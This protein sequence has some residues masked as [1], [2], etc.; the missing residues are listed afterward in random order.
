MLS[1]IKEDTSMSDIVSIDWHDE[2]KQILLVTYHRDGWQ[3]NDFFI[4]LKQ[5]YAFIDSVNHTVDVLVDVQNSSWIPKGGSLLSGLR[6]I[7]EQHPRQGLTIIVGAKGLVASIARSM[8]KMLGENRRFHF[9]ATMEEAHQLIAKAQ[10][11]RLV[12]A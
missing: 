3:W 12:Q 10:A 7:E 1:K 2:D 6:K 9:V 8:M 11:K 5:Q 4:V